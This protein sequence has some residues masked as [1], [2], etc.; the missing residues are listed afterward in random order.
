MKINTGLQSGEN[1]A[2]SGL[3][4]D[5][6]SRNVNKSGGNGSCATVEEMGKA[7]GDCDVLE[8]LRIRRLIREHF[9]IYGIVF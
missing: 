2:D 5:S 1:K 6:G 3:E 9:D 4:L 7:F 8:S